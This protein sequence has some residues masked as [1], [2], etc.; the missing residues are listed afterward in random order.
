M[1]LNFCVKSLLCGLGILLAASV[2]VC[3]QNTVTLPVDSPAFAFSPG[4][5]TGDTDRGGSV[6]RQ[7]WYPGAYFRVTWS[8]TNANPTAQILLDPSTYGDAVKTPPVLT[9]NVDGVWTD[10]VACGPDHLA[11]TGLK[12]AGTHVLT[13]Y[14]KVSNQSARWGAPGTSGKNVVRVT[15]LQVDSA[16]TAGVSAHAPKWALIIGDSITE[17]SAANFGKSDELA[18]WSYF[19]GQS[20]LEEGCEY[21]VS[22]CGYSGWLNPGDAEGDVLPYYFI[23]DS[24]NGAGGTYHDD[25]SRWNKIDGANHSFLDSNQHLSAYGGT[26]QEPSLILINYGTNDGLHQLNTSDVQASI[27]QSIAA[28]R[29]AAPQAAIFL[30]VPFG[31]YYAKPLQDGLAAYRSQHPDDGKVYLID[32][33]PQAAAALDA[34][35]YW[36]G[37]HPNMRGHATFAAQILGLMQTLQQPPAK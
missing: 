7:T 29:G 21:E 11:V 23:S 25:R 5:W 19:V 13:A 32:L 30:I 37:L 17:G 35:G 3:A 36:S 24:K 2:P 28:L 1:P 26:G 16:A 6:F 14:L 8:T 4:N 15:G 22:A 10:D 9:Y 12:G 18:S 33:G 27:T 31:Q 34:N 20:L